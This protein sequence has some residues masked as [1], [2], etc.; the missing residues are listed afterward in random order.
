MRVP[1]HPREDCQSSSCST[2]SWRS[3]VPMNLIVTI[4][5]LLYFLSYSLSTDH[6]GLPVVVAGQ[7]SQILEGVGE[8]LVVGGGG[9]D[10]EVGAVHG[11]LLPCLIADVLPY[12]PPR[13]PRWPWPCP[14]RH[15]ACHRLTD[16]FVADLATTVFVEGMG[17]FLL[18]RN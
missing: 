17:K 5:S 10:R 7:L 8:T 4:L 11:V 13:W 12:P 9:V 2:S 3:S 1:I 15:S 16:V 18:K 14:L 6:R